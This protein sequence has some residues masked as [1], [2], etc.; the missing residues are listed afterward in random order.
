MERDRAYL[1]DIVVSARLALSYVEGLDAEEFL[2][3]RQIQDSVVRRLE[4]I[5]EAA[6][7]LSDEVRAELPEIPWRSVIGMRNIMIHNYDDVDFAIVWSTVQSELP[8]LI[9]V[10]EPHLPPESA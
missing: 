7:R 1:L 9:A 8:H 2:D 6:G 5:G 3:D 10:I 4:I